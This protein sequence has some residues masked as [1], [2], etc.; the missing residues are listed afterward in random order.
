MARFSRGVMQTPDGN[1]RIPNV[2]DLALTLS[3]V[4]PAITPV[5]NGGPPTALTTQAAGENIRETISLGDGQLN[6]I[7]LQVK[8]RTEQAA[9]G[10]NTTGTIRIRRNDIN[11]EIIAS[12]TYNH[13]GGFFQSQLNVTDNNVRDSPNIYVITGQCTSNN[14]TNMSVGAGI[15]RSTR[16][17][18]ISAI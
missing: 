10:S 11:G 14:S 3:P 5:G 16:T 1:R 4:Q 13:A 2:P 7:E 8:L 6:F 18:E 17:T 12:I 15:A 9:A